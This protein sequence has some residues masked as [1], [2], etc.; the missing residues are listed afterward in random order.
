MKVAFL[1]T[2][3]ANMYCGS[4][5]RDN[6]LAATLQSLGHDVTLLPMYTPMRV[7]EPEAKQTHVFY[8]GI[9]AYLLQRFPQPSWWREALLR[10]AGSQAILRLMPRFD[11]GSAVDP[12]ANAELT[13]SML[14]GEQGQQ[15][16][17]LHEMV[18]WIADE[19]KPDL[20]HVTNTLI[21]GVVPALKQR[22]NVPIVC[23]LHGEDIFLEGLPPK[24]YNQAVQIIQ[25]NAAFIDH[26]IAISQYYIEYFTPQV[27]LDRQRITLVRPGIN[28][29]DYQNRPRP[30]QAETGPT[31]GYLARI[32]PEKGLHLLAEAFIRLA[33]TG[34]FPGLR[35]RAAGYL[36]NVQANYVAGI[37]KRLQENGLSEQAEIIGTVGRQGKLDFLASLDVFA[38]PTIYRDP[39]GLPVLEALASG[40]PVVQPNHGAFPEL[41]QATG[42]GLLHKPEDPADLAEKLADLLR[43]DAKR[44]SLAEHGRSA[45]FQHFTAERMAHETMSVYQKVLA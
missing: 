29:A 41:V 7:D 32:S 44:R 25:H 17:L 6:T 10:L 8:G 35:L 19:L 21:S 3:A 42:G 34:E 39:K 12:E 1:A 45:V 2:G 4:C 23:G 40:V 31:I 28:L 15:A 37:R 33:K 27:S 11:I 43:D 38:V 16:P 13:L 20:I 22:L 26:F 24:Y 36:S 9:A 14:R 30:P 5:M 18:A